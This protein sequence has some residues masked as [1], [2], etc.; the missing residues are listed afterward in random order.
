MQAIGSV[1]AVLLTFSFWMW[2]RH[3]LR[4]VR[5]AKELAAALIIRP[6]LR[7]WAH[8]ISAFVAAMTP[9][10][11]AEPVYWLV[12]TQDQYTLRAPNELRAM[13][14]SFGDLG[15]P[16]GEIAEL[17]AYVDDLESWRTSIVRGDLT[18]GAGPAATMEELERDAKALISEADGAQASARQIEWEVRRF[19][20][21]DIH[22]RRPHRL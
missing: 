6:P 13:A 5:R 3:K 15:E 7:D 22:P 18:P 10:E 2:D 8:Q 1:S 9:T 4:V 11:N 17:I 20:L 16:G 21:P 19:L 14:G 12:L